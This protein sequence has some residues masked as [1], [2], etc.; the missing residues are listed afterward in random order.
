M[1]LGSDSMDETPK[2]DAGL[3]LTL[4]NTPAGESSLSHLT[5]PANLAEIVDEGGAEARRAAEARVKPYQTPVTIDV[6]RSP[7]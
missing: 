1:P 5:A 2:G 7:V 6:L 3:G 4:W